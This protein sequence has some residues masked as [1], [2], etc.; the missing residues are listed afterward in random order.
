MADTV[1]AVVVAFNRKVL[2][3]ECLRGLLQQTHPVDAV[4]VIDNASTDGTETFLSE[5]GLLA[6]PKIRYTVLTKNIGGAGGFAMGMEAAFSAGYAWIWFMDDDAEPFADAL[7]RFLSFMQDKETGALANL[8]LDTNGNVLRYHLGS[9]QWRSS[10]DLVCPLAHESTSVSDRIPVEFSSF[11]GLLIRRESIAKVG[12][13]R[14]EFFIHCDDFEYSVRLLAVGRIFL[15]PSSKILH[16]EKI[17]APSLEKHWGSSTY[18][19]VP[20]EKYAFEFFGIRNRFWTLLHHSTEAKFMRHVRVAR[21]LAGMAVRIVLYERDYR[22]LRLQLLTR[23]AVDALQGRF[24]NSI[25]FDTRS[26]LDRTRERA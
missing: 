10:L 14:R 20:I 7:E 12:F 9:I 22:F 23:G 24:N 5:V 13:P 21:D 19:C 26:R 18:R 4:F 1:A 15:I 6:E 17:S 2:L 8:K 3:A 11:I 25:P 16:K